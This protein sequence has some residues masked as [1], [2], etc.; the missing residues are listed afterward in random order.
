[1]KFLSVFLFGGAALSAAVPPLN[2]NDPGCCSCS[3]GTEEGYDG[4]VK[5]CNL[6]IASG[7]CIT[8]MSI[9]GPSD[10]QRRVYCPADTPI[11]RVTGTNLR[12][13]Q[14]PTPPEGKKWCCNSCTTCRLVDEDAVCPQNK[15]ACLQGTQTAQVN[16][17]ENDHVED[18]DRTFPH[19]GGL[20]M[21]P[22]AEE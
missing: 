1:M 2:N 11:V 21:L 12:A 15:M 6:G 9:G 22:A 4:Y 18:P 7:D 17:H 3:I 19:R 5:T 20:G 8:T 13:D 14:A 10:I 16:D